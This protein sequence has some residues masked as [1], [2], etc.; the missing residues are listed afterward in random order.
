MSLIDHDGR[1]GGGDTWWKERG[2][3]NDEQQTVPM[4]SSSL[5]S[6]LHVVG[7]DLGLVSEQNYHHPEVEEKLGQEGDQKTRGKTTD[8]RDSLP[9]T[10][11][12][13]DETV[14]TVSRVYLAEY[15]KG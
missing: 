14:G 2:W 9:C 4:Q 1:R 6:S 3:G 5:V 10:E 7:M 13:T 12:Q 15:Y 8:G 11:E